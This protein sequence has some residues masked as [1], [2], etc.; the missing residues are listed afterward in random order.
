MR[1]PADIK[2]SC[3]SACPS[4]EDDHAARLRDRFCRGPDTKV[5][6][7]P[8]LKVLEVDGAYAVGAVVA[9]LEFFEAR[10]NSFRVYL[11]S[12]LGGWLFLL[13]QSDL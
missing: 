4:L 7:V 11:G 1:E 13:R 6:L 12:N 3:V 8:N 2:A 9:E 10:D 5:F